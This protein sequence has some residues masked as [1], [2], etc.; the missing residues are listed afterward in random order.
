MR[1][2]ICILLAAL[3]SN[4]Y[5][6]GWHTLSKVTRVTVRGEKFY[7]RGSDPSGESC[8]DESEFYGTLDHFSS[9]AGHDQYYTLALTAQTTGKGISCYIYQKRDSGVCVMAN[10]YIP[11]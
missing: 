10:C 8:T 4:A 11:E 9:E 5:S 1:Y 2:F 6:A 7:V 3:F